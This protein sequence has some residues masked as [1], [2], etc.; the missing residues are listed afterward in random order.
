MLLTISFVIALVT[1]ISLN[2]LVSFKKI[3]SERDSINLYTYTAIKQITGKNCGAMAGILFFMSY[4]GAIAYY[5]LAFAEA[6]ISELVH[7]EIFIVNNTQESQIYMF[8][9]IQITPW[10]KPGSWRVIILGTLLLLILTIVGL[11]KRSVSSVIIPVMVMIVILTTYL[12][13]IIMLV[14]PPT[15]HIG[16]VTGNTGW[17]QKTFLANSQRCDQIFK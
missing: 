8:G 9:R 15:D 1:V 7:A 17:L 3:K 5:C 6:T 10:N 14:W 2:V 11:F 12:L 13:S 16:N 4:C